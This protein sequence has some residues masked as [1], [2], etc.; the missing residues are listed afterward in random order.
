MLA[1]NSAKERIVVIIKFILLCTE[2]FSLLIDTTVSAF[3]S[4]LCVFLSLPNCWTVVSYHC[5]FTHTHTDNHCEQW[6]C[7]NV[8]STTEVQVLS[9]QRYAMQFFSK[10][11]SKMFETICQRF[12]SISL[13]ICFIW[14]KNLL[15]ILFGAC[16][17]FEY[18]YCT[19]KC[20]VSN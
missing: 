15:N 5:V 12:L 20:T 19:V 14:L 6:F 10:V 16:F 8:A 13:K 17:M 7:R 2:S 18:K 1:S 4:H 9:L 11:R 3:C